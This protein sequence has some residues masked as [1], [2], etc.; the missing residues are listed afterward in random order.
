MV[1]EDS[2]TCK[3]LTLLLFGPQK[4][5]NTKNESTKNVIMNGVR[6]IVSYYKFLTGQTKSSVTSW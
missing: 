4:W 3:M 1:L 2:Y 5:H 6:Q